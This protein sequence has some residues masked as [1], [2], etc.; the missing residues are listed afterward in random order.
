[1]SRGSPV[2]L[3]G[4]P[5]V[6]PGPLLDRV[7]AMGVPVLISANAMPI[8]K[9]SEQQDWGRREFIEFDPANLRHLDGVDSY[10]DSA[11]FVG[12]AWLSDWDLDIGDAENPGLR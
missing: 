7:R 10:L 11:G 9:W 5:T 8:A 2:F 3:V 6:Y 1:M 12:I 4:L